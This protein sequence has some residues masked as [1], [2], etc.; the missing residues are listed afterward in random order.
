MRHAIAFCSVVF[1]LITSQRARAAETLA[2]PVQSPRALAEDERR[3]IENGM[4]MLEKALGTI[5]DRASSEFAD[6][7]IYH[8][9]L[10]WALR[11]D[12]EFTES[13]IALL[14]QAISRGQERAESLAAGQ[15]P[16]RRGPRKT[17]LGYVSRVD[18]S[19]QPY[20]VIVPRG[21]DSARPARLDVVLHGSTRPVGMSELRFMARFDERNDG[22]GS[23]P[24]QS[25]I[26]LHPLGRVENCYRWAGETDV[27]EAIEDVCRRYNIDRDRIVLRGM[28]MGASG[29]WHLGLKHPD[30]FV[31][32][33]PYCGYVDTHHFSETPLPNF[34]AVGPLPEHQEL[35]LHMLDS[36]D[37]AA[38]AGIVPVVACMGEK[39]VFFQAHEL[40]GK[41]FQRE[42]LTLTNLISPGTGHVIDPVTHA[43]QLR[44]ISEYAANG[45]SRKPHELR[46]VT[47]TLKYS[48]CHWLEVLGLDRH[49]TRA[50]LSAHLSDGVLHMSEPKNITRFAIRT[51]ELPS[52]PK[53]LHIAKV[54][55]AVPPSI[56]AESPGVVVERAAGSWQIA[57]ELGRVPLSGKRPGLQGPI[58]DA[59]T[60]PF[61]C[62]RGTGQ[63]WNAAVHAYAEASLRRFA[64]EWHH[65]FRGALLVK[66]DTDVIEEDLRTRNLILFGDPG[67][68]SWI[69]RVLPHLP[70]AWSKQTVRFGTEEYAAAD[71]VPA[72]IAPN[73]LP[74]ADAHYV[75]LNSGHTFREAELAK[76]NYL[77]FPRW[78]DWAIIEIS[79]A[80]PP[81]AP[82]AEKVLRAGY[83]DEQWRLP[84]GNANP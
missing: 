54:D 17:A 43:E 36:I 49:Y 25:F 47:W 78:G 9:G 44:R 65:Y 40:M 64:D 28:S 77:L 42:G 10:V 32:L 59:F 70:L 46:F 73:P 55:I 35:G 66:D 56:T 6:A 82:V 4:R 58:D 19:I 61:L 53:Q 1:L 51:A 50:E 68:N 62:V 30:R 37:Y 22:N 63:P 20:G 13:D 34:V 33:G 23:L 21:Y 67:N 5:D 38:N 2:G 41:A 75:V 45:I 83:F 48:R 16:W 7:A 12:R 26:E 71:H 80:S 31:V 76:L 69:A 29:T 74:D 11:Y 52:I 79:A 57:G 39:D 27:F 24:D 60:T 8:K 81:F 14:H 18:R 72:L 3:E 84:A 15:L